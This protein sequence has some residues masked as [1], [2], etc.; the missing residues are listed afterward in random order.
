ML[1][2]ACPAARMGL[3]ITFCIHGSSSIMKNN[4]A[5]GGFVCSTRRWRACSS[6]VLR[7]SSLPTGAEAG[8]W[9]SGL[10]WPE[11]KVVDPG[12][13]GGP[14]SDA[15]VLFDGKDLSQFN[16]GEKWILKDGYGICQGG[17]G[18]QAVVRRLPVARRMGLARGRS[19]ATAKAAATAAST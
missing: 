7:R 3:S 2:K 15:I 19:K 17:S 14:P 8:E 10:V 1:K 5:N 6:W 16:G 12:P 9:V 18:H 4:N 13:V 11:P